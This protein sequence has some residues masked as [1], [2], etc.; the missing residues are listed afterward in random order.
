MAH[1][2]IASLRTQGT[3]LR[4]M[5]D[6]A[7]RLAVQL[8]PATVESFL[9]SL[10]TIEALL[11]ELEASGFDVRPEATRW[12]SLLNRVNSHPQP[13]VRAASS[14]GGMAQLRAAN[15][16][17]ESFWW[18]LDTE[19]AQRRRKAISRAAVTLASIII[20][21]VGA[22]WALETF[23]PPDPIAVAMVETTSLLDRMTS[24]QD[25]E[26]ALAVVQDARQRLP[27]QLELA[28]WET[29]LHER[30]EDPV[31]A[32]RTLAEAEAMTQARPI[33]LY[34]Q[35]GNKRLLVNDLDGA[36]AAA[37]QGAAMAPEEAQITFLLG[38]IAE[39]RGQLGTAID[40]FQQ[41]FELAQEENPQLAVIARVRMG[42]LMQSP[43][44][45][46]ESDDSGQQP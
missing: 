42:Q 5:L 3:H 1:T 38:G 24:E 11:T 43:D 30:L 16:P 34:I 35:L 23:F 19:V 6:K 12:E 29:V 33:D 18:H 14:V 32:A 44:S 41:T 31:A 13:I 17:A 39:A 37:Q 10:D 46:F 28:V 25:W 21:V 36:E 4:E 2:V 22:L 45:F 15:P 8:E 40:Y 20:I 9:K 27:D 7:E 26:G